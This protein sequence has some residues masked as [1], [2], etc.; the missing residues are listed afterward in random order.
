MRSG[1]RPHLHSTDRIDFNRFG[2][3]IRDDLEELMASTSYA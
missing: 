2:G 3:G 1:L